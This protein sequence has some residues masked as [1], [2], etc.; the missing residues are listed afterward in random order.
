MVRRKKKPDDSVESSGGEFG[1]G[2]QD[3]SRTKRWRRPRQLEEPAFSPSLEMPPMGRVHGAF[4]KWRP[5]AAQ[6]KSRAGALLNFGSRRDQARF[7]LTQSC[8]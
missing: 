8:P 7:W 3:Q 2:G 1:A 4:D 5:E 6:G